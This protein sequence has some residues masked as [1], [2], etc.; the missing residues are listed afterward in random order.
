MQCSR[1]AKSGLVEIQM[2]I[3][4]E[5]VTFRSCGRCEAKHWLAADGPLELSRVLEMARAAA[6][7]TDR[8]LRR[9]Q[10]RSKRNTSSSGGPSGGALHSRPDAKPTPRRSAVSRL[11]C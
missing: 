7:L 11:P 6:P 4:N 1:C 5:D 9:A 2:K 10:A 8:S 3:G